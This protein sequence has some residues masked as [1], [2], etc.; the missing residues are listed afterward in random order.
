LQRGISL[1]PS[2]YEVVFTSL[3]HTDAEVIRTIDA[4]GE[5]AEVVAN[6]MGR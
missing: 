1:A 5:A 3:A 4:A 6:S 2:A